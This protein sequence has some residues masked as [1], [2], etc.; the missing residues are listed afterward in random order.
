M[1]I[2]KYKIGSLFILFIFFITISTTVFSQI[3]VFTPTKSSTIIDSLEVTKQ[4]KLSDVNKEIEY[5]ETLITKF[6]IYK[7]NKD[8]FNELIQ[9]TKVINKYILK[10][11]KEFND[12]ESSN[13]SHYFLRNAHYTWI[14]YYNE[15][16]EFQETIQVSIRKTQNHQSKF[17]INNE[18]WNNN[19][20]YLKNKVSNHILQR[21]KS[22]N[23]QSKKIVKEYDEQIK[24][25]LEIEDKIIENIIFIERITS[26]INSYIE[27]KQRN[28]FKKTNPSM[29][30]INYSNSYNGRIID[31]LSLAYYENTKTFAYFILKI[32]DNLLTYI[33]IV[34]LLIGY[35]LNLRRN[36]LKLGLGDD[37]P[38]YKIVQ[39]IFISKIFYIFITIALIAW[40]IVIPYTPLFISK[41]IYIFLLTIMLLIISDSFDKQSKSITIT[42]ITLLVIN[43]LEMFVWYFGDYSR[44]YLLFETVLAIGLV[45]PFLFGKKR[46]DIANSN[47]KN[48]LVFYTK[49]ISP[50]SLVLFIIAFF[51]NIFGILNLSIYILSFTI[52]LGTITIIAFSFSKIFKSIFLAN[53]DVLANKYPNYF[54]NDGGRIL[55]KGNKIINL[56]FLIAWVY[57]LLQISQIFSFFNAKFTDLLTSGISIGNFSFRFGDVLLFVTIIYVSISINKFIKKFIEREVLAKRELERGSAAAI[58]LTARIFIIFFGFTIALSAAGVD[59]TRISIIAGALSVGIGFGLQSIVSNFV[60]GLILIYERPLQE[61]DTVEVGALLGKVTNIG[62]RASNVI[63]YDGAEVVVPNNNLVSNELINWT[64]SDSKKRIKLLVGVKYGSDPNIVLELLAKVCEEHPKILP[65]PKPLPLFV[66]F[67]DSSLDFKVQFWVDYEDGIQT[68]SDIHVAIYNILAENNIEIPFPQI[69]LHVKDILGKEY[70]EAKKNIDKGDAK[71][72]KLPE[73]KLKPQKTMDI[74]EE[75]DDEND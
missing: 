36:Y 17:I 61:G 33:I 34:S 57:A 13:L 44:F 66:G 8:E 55:H 19:I 15:L 26:N 11:G 27:K 24:S 73:K 74:D 67:G 72:D 38:G 39:R 70:D 68:S 28:M 53:I 56:V 65:F 49:L 32:K 29:F 4:I 42:I 51:G 23:K 64:L 60:S 18:K 9:R 25:L 7:K 58:S 71:T 31:R 21:I 45:T 46:Q 14:R 69:D 47:N 20:P 63:T 1:Q 43:N 54:N 75:K 6:N 50:I 59:M 48:S 52:N 10:Q 35:L 2:S 12:F 62:I 16:R 3:D 5:T 22:K 30:S 37:T 40:A 41:I